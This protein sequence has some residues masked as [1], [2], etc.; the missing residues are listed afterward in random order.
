[1]FCSGIW[2]W[3]AVGADVVMV[4]AVA[5]DVGV[6]GAVIAV[7]L[8]LDPGVVVASVGLLLCSC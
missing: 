4:V 2:Y 5:A 1:M 8:V 3:P 7:A 6:V